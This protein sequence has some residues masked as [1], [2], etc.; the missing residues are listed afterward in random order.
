M[1]IALAGDIHLSRR[2]FQDDPVPGDDA[3]Q[4]QGR[5][6]PGPGEGGGPGV[7]PSQASR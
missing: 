7:R 6:Q 3:A 1:V 2:G 4:G 5:G